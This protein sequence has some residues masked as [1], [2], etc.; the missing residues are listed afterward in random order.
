[1]KLIYVEPS[2]VLNLT[3][4][5]L[6]SRVHMHNYVAS[7]LLFRIISMKMVHTLSETFF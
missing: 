7:L 5:K 2:V 6:E 1:M 4:S 3:D